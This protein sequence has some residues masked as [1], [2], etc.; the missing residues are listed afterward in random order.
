MVVG[1]FDIYEK[2]KDRSLQRLIEIHMRR[3]EQYIF[4]VTP[5]CK[6]CK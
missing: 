1:V 3:F 6:S 4:G 2:A 5:T